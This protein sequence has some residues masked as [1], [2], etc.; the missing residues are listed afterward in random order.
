[1]QNQPIKSRLI[2]SVV[3]DEQTQFLDV[4]LRS[5]KL[6]RFPNVSKTVY[7]NLLTAE[8]PG[9]YYTYHIRKGEPEAG[10]S[11]GNAFSVISYWL[12]LERIFLTV[13]RMRR[14]GK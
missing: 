7:D 14:R 11:V 1:M 12:P 13:R 3:Y 4:E 9:W 2:K 8:S 6:R 5:G 10:S